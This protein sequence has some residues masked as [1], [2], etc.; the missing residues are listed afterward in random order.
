MLSAI[1]ATLDSERTLVPTLAALVPGATAG[2]LGEV[3][4]ADG[5]SS[6]ATAEVADIAGCRFIASSDALGARLKAAVASTRTPWL[7]FLRAGCV[8]EPGWI[9]TVDRFMETTDQLDGAAR[10]AVFR[11][12][13]AGDLLHPRLSEL[14]ALLRVML[15]GGAKPDQGLLMARRFYEEIAGHPEG[16]D[17]E[18]A[19]LRKI[20]RRRIAMLPI[21]AGKA[22]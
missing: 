11:P 20:G 5:G 14:A 1:I 10:A 8:L 12:P 17:T 19:L 2:L 7:M 3:I 22:R 15:I 16:S 4:V 18:A 21:G 6:D 13:G 9:Q